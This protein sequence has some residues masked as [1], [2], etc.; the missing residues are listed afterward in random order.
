M[1]SSVWQT[2]LRVITQAYPESDPVQQMHLKAV[3]ESELKILGV[4]DLEIN[5][6]SMRMSEFPCCPVGHGRTGDQAPFFW[7]K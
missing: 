2:H 7:I 3:Q 6:L 4:A 1:C 5:V